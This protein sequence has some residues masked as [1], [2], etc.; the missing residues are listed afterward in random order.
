MQLP[1]SQ[2]TFALEMAPDCLYNFT[3][4]A[5]IYI[6][7]QQ[8]T[9]CIFVFLTLFVI[10]IHVQLNILWKQTVFHK[11]LYFTHGIFQDTFQGI[12]RIYSLV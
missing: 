1:S 9:D 2:F 10:L 6:N 7:D 3:G 12:L 11:H 8:I 5:E 4:L